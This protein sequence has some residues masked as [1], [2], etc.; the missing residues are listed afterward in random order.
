MEPEIPKTTENET[1]IL[2]KMKEDRHEDKI[3]KKHSLYE[4]YACSVC[5][6][7]MTLKSKHR[8]EKTK[9][10][11]QALDLWFNRFEMT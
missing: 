3:G 6:S 9:K 4:V 2:K 10:H 8:H 5:G 7:Q 1:Q 11:N